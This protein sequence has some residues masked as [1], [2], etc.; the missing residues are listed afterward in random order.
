MCALTVVIAIRF[1]VVLFIL[2]DIII[3]LVVILAAVVIVM[4]DSNAAR[5]SQG[6][7]QKDG[8]SF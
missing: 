4:M 6:K 8:Q 5:E 3:F 7:S 1:T 2:P